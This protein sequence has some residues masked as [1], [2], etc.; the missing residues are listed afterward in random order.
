MKTGRSAGLAG[1]Q[2]QGGQGRSLFE[3][4]VEIIL[5][6][7]QQ[8]LPL[9]IFEIECAHCRRAAVCEP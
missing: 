6:E 4:V 9:P 7:D 1:I 3:K 5:V 8:I 2:P